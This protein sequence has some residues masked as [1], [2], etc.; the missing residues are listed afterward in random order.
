MFLVIRKKPVIFLHWYHHVTVLL[1]CWHAWHIVAGY[2]I[3]FATMNFSVHSIMYSYYFATNI[4]LFKLV[5]P[6]APIITFLQIAQMI[7]GM[8]ILIMVA[9]Y[10]STATET[11]EGGFEASSSSYKPDACNVDAANLKLGLAMYFSYFVLFAMFFWE[12]YIGGSSEGNVRSH[13]KIE[14]KD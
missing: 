4:G 10:V 5:R 1:F 12:K 11:T 2:G 9:K 7:A 13:K 14:K 8:F 6:F 3:W